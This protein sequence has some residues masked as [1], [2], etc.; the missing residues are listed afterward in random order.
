MDTT[1]PT[2]RTRRQTGNPSPQRDQTPRWAPRSQPPS[3]PPRTQ[4]RGRQCTRA[5][6]G[7]TVPSQL[8]PTHPNQLP[9]P[10]THVATPQ[11]TEKE[12]EPL[13]HHPSWTPLVLVR[14]TEPT[15]RTP[16]VHPSTAPALPNTVVVRS[17]PRSIAYTNTT[18]HTHGKESFCSNRKSRRW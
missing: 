2:A 7:P 14:Q 5:A 3:P 8:Q 6:S 12:R 17:V 15:T 18:H 9:V 16:F 1:P 4:K 13:R 11:L 10:P